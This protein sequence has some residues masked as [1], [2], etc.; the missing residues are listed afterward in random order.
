MTETIQA[1]N[2]IKPFY[3]TPERGKQLLLIEENGATLKQGKAEVKGK[4][5]I[6]QEWSPMGLYWDFTGADCG[7]LSFGEVELES[8]SFCANGQLFS[9]GQ[10][11]ASGFIHGKVEIDPDEKLTRV[12]FHLPNFPDLVAGPVYPGSETNGA[13]TSWSQILL[14]SGK[15]RIVIQPYQDIFTL[16]MKAREHQSVVLSGIGDIRR[17]D[18]KEFEK[19]HVEPVI[20][21]LRLFLSFALADWSPPMFVVGSSAKSDRSWEVWNNHQV[22]PNPFISGWVDERH[23]QS[24]ATAFPGF[25]KLWKN[26]EWQEPLET[27]VTWLIEASKQSGGTEGAIA[28]SQIPLEMLAWMVFV[29]QAPI[30]DSKDFKP[31]TAAGKLQLLLTNCGIPLEV[32]KSL[33]SLRTVAKS[34]NMSGP[35]IATEIRNAIIHPHKSNRKL[36]K[37]WEDKHKVNKYDLLRETHQLFKSYITLVLLNLIGYSGKYANRLTPRKQGDVELVPWANPVGKEAEV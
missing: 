7:G 4:V 26:K 2:R 12:T 9:I 36:L 1:P 11:Q 35:K 17:V 32:P 10:N 18:G 15:W 16:R 14:G 19:K 31:I 5:K 6:T 29:E 34:N 27:A 21:A 3:E 37:G 13:T 20:E 24:L 33:I 22:S 23:G 30:V 28:F 25:M 8:K